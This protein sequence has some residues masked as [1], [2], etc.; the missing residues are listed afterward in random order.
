MV[1]GLEGSLLLLLDH[2]NSWLVVSISVEPPRG[3]L[4]TCPSD[5]MFWWA[6]CV[7]YDAGIALRAQGWHSVTELYLLACFVF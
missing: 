3:L 2:V 1:R 5:L 4:L 7:M 6:V